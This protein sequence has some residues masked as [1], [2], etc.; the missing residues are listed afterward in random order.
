[1]NRANMDQA[2]AGV[3]LTAPQA[4]HILIAGFFVSHH[5]PFNVIASNK[6]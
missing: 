4:A 3:G 2:I 1:M 6:E 5:S